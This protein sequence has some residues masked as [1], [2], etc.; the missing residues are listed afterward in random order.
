MGSEKTRCLW[1]CDACPS[2]LS[3]W[4]MTYKSFTDKHGLID[5]PR[6]ELRGEPLG[7]VLAGEPRGEGIEDEGVDEPRGGVRAGD[8]G[9]EK[10]AFRVC[11]RRESRAGE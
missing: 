2:P 4:N 5:E 9:G 6:D 1:P 10:E 11:V 8:L 7:G 3:L